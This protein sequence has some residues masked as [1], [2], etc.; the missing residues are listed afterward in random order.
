MIEIT[1]TRC[2]GCIFLRHRMD[3]DVRVM[4]QCFVYDRQIT[5]EMLSEPCKFYMQRVKQ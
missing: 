2:D 4:D 1:P 5:D 3:G